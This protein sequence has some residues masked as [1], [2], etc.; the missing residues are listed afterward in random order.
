VLEKDEIAHDVQMSGKTDPQI[1]LEI[2]AALGIDEETARGHVPGVLGHLESEL[3][4]AADE[5]RR[6]GRV[7]PGVPEVLATLHADDNVLQSALTGNT[8]VNAVAKLVAF[9]LDRWIDVEV[10]AYGSDSAD[11]RELVPIALERAAR[12]RARRFDPAQV[13]VVGDT[14]HDLACAK[15]A[16]VR[17]ILVATGRVTKDE[18]VGIGADAVLDDLSDAESVAALLTC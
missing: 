15:A 9:G 13:W 8:Q 5:L 2:L 14:P 18:L 7:L 17:C 16:G 4:A 6:G 11:R 1:A 3:G 12:L 10:G